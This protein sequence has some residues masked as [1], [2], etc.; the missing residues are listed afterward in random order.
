MVCLWPWRFRV[1]SAW[2]LRTY[3]TCHVLDIYFTNK[4]TFTVWNPHFS[5]FRTRQGL[6][7]CIPI[8]ILVIQAGF[9]FLECGSIRAKNATNIL[10]KNL[11]DSCKNLPIMYKST[12]WSKFSLFEW[13]SSWVKVGVSKIIETKQIE[14]TSMHSIW[15]S[16]GF[17]YYLSFSAKTFTFSIQ[18][19][20]DKQIW[21]I[22][23]IWQK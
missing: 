13:K 12:L 16:I 6:F 10:L 15:L 19:F 22:C 5:D 21:Q 1:F 7:K 14:M 18:V 8:Y 4:T 17:F 20:R 11:L 3:V 9:G 2:D 23:Q